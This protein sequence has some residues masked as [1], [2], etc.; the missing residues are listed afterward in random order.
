[1]STGDFAHSELSPC[2]TSYTLF[3]STWLETKVRVYDS[4]H[5]SSTQHS[6]HELQYL[7]LV[8][9][10]C[11]NHKFTGFDS[12]GLETL[13]FHLTS[14]WIFKFNNALPPADAPYEQRMRSA[15]LPK[16]R[17]ARGASIY[18]ANNISFYFDSVP[19]C[20][21]NLG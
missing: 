17:R 11:L 9:R 8:K 1:M 4:S 2:T 13:I 19:P 21:Q 14:D 6:S 5:S 20:L 16:L 7:K 18:D 3:I 10:S 15:R 12:A